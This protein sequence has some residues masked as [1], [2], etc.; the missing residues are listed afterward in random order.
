MQDKI[1]LK[2]MRTTNELRTKGR[3][4]QH[5]TLISF[6]MMRTMIS[7]AIKHSMRSTKAFRR[8]TIIIHRRRGEVTSTSPSSHIP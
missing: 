1:S 8:N 4:Y 3:G 5:F 6:N 7:A 2:K